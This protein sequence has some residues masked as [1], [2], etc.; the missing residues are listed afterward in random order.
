MDRDPP[1]VVDPPLRRADRALA[2]RAREAI[3]VSKANPESALDPGVQECE[4]TL[5][6]VEERPL[7]RRLLL[8]EMKEEAVEAGKSGDF[9][10]Q[11]RLMST[12][13]AEQSSMIRSSVE[14]LGRRFLPLH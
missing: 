12:M 1:V 10:E 5:D 4:E 9:G 8:L 13:A 6:P 2:S 7:A 3:G 14:S 11:E